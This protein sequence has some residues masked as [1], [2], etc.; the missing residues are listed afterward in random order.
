MKIFRA[1]TTLS[2]LLA[3][4]LLASAAQA[5][6]WVCAA[7]YLNEQTIT[8]FVR[9]EGYFAV[10]LSQQGSEDKKFNQDILAEDDSL[11]IVGEF[12]FGELGGVEMRMINK[13]TNRYAVDGVIFAKG[14]GAVRQD[15]SCT[16][17]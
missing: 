9:K 2:L 6:T 8:T 4:L 12:R 15:G 11:L 3:T 17:I 5:E 13:V 7:I 10:T 1:L 16:K 14:F